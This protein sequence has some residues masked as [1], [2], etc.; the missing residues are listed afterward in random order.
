MK[1]MKML[2]MI[3]SEISN[4]NKKNDGRLRSKKN[5]LVFWSKSECYKD[6]LDFSIFR[7]MP[8]MVAAT[9]YLII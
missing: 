6:C 4:G 8:V 7:S 2:G 3:L 9:N 5:P 1:T